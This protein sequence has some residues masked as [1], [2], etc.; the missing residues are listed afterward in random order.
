V[1]R[2]FLIQ[3]S[4]QFFI[5]LFCVVLQTILDVYNLFYLNIVS[6]YCSDPTHRK[7]DR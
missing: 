1:G 5:I 3:Q 2:I 6:L 7:I 4:V